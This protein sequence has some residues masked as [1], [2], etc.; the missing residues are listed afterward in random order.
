VR[1]GHLCNSG[2]DYP[3]VR[4]RQNVPRAHSECRKKS[5]AAWFSARKYVGDVICDN[6]LVSI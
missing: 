4:L 1:L 6:T 3:A 5:E 2:V